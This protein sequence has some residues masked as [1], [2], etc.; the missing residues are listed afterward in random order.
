MSD[1]IP[2]PEEAR[3]ALAS[4]YETR[5]KLAAAGNYPPGRHI[6]FGLL[7][8]FHNALPLLTSWNGIVQLLLFSAAIFAIYRWDLKT[9]GVFINGWRRGKTLWVSIFLVT[10]IMVLFAAQMQLRLTSPGSWLSF[11]L[12]A[13]AFAFGTAGSVLWARVF[14]REMAGE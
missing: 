10:G 8:A 2:T 3:A 4:A 11:G 12:L 13:L 1:K 6:A 14:R 5:R 7:I 9:Y